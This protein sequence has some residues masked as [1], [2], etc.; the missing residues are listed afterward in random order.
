M[1]QKYPLPITPAMLAVANPYAGYPR[2]S[3]PA[4]WQ[5]GIDGNDVDVATSNVALANSASIT[6]TP[7][8]GPRTQAEKAALIGAVP[9]EDI[10]I[11]YGE[12]TGEMGRTGTIEPGLPYPDATTVVEP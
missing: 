7:A 3:F 6:P 2:Y 8:Y 10:G 4:D 12:F 9:G 11:D 1:G 5:G